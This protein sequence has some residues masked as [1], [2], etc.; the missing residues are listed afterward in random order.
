MKPLSILVEYDLEGVECYSH[1]YAYE[2]DNFRM[3]EKQ[4]LRRDPALPKLTALPLTDT[5]CVMV[6]TVEGLNLMIR[7]LSG[8]TEIGVDLEAHNYRTYLGLTC[9]VQ[10]LMPQNKTF[11]SDM[12]A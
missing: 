12:I 5:P 7:E 8:F 4:M 10:V 3:P 2:I 1:P 11:Q 6:N 9:L